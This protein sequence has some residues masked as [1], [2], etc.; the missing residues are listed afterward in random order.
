MGQPHTYGAESQTRGADRR[1][2]G[3]GPIDVGLGLIVRVVRHFGTFCASLVGR[4][5]TYGADPHL[6]GRVTLMG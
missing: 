3:E 1:R 5:H 4:T 6:W 2:V